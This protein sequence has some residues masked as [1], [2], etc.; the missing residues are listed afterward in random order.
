MNKHNT[1]AIVYDV[2][3]HYHFLLLIFHI[4]CRPVQLRYQIFIQIP[5]DSV[6]QNSRTNTKESSD[7]VK[8]EQ[9]EKKPQLSAT[10]KRTAAAKVCNDATNTVQSENDQILFVGDLRPYA[11]HPPLSMAFSKYTLVNMDRFVSDK[12]TI[13]CRGYELV[14][15]GNAAYIR[16]EIK[17]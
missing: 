5:Y 7:E 15:T 4:N 10:V 12:R 8:L 6:E 1:A 3:C 13:A 2:H 14:G 16:S 11:A 17:K 9:Q